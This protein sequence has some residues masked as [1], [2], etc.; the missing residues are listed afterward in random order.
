M[1]NLWIAQ[2]Y[3]EALQSPSDDDVWAPLTFQPAEKVAFAVSRA[4][5][6]LHARN[7]EDCMT[8]SRAI[9]KMRQIMDTLERQRAL[10]TPDSD[11]GQVWLLQGRA[12]YLWMDT[13]DISGLNVD[14]L[15]WFEVFAI[16][17][18]MLCEDFT[19]WTTA[20]APAT[21]TPRQ[22]AIRERLHHRAAQLFPD[23][24]DGL[25]RAEVLETLGRVH[26]F[27]KLLGRKG[28][29]RRILKFA[30]L[31]AEVSR[32]YFSGHENMPVLKA[33]NC[34]AILIAET[35]PELLLLTRNKDKPVAIQNIIRKFKDGKAKVSL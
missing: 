13:F 23:I 5:Q 32:L 15:E 17:V 3:D 27:A 30:P 10:N 11:A 9:R 16:K 35:K 14:K 2:H 33:A 28:G 21:D 31:E 26:T 6:L 1:N 12:L 24:I 20:K 25:A 19:R 8:I 7:H 4:R 34:I 29:K 18:L 22:A